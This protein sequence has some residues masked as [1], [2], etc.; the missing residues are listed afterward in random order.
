GEGLHGDAGF[1]ASIGG[2]AAPACG[3]ALSGAAPIASVRVLLPPESRCDNTFATNRSVAACS[4]PPS[5]GPL[6]ERRRATGLRGFTVLT[7]LCRTRYG[8]SPD[9]DHPAHQEWRATVPEARYPMREP[10]HLLATGDCG[11][12]PARRV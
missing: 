2:R 10:G 7:R 4:M 3:A 8:A 9:N 6:H 1:G 5:S 12:C 11:D